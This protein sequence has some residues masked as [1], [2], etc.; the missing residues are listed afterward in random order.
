MIDDFGDR[1]KEYES[2]WT[3]Q[4]I[5]PNGIMCVR[6]DGRSFSKFTKNLK[7]PFDERFSNAMQ[8]TA[9]ELHNEF[10]ADLT[11]VQSD[12]ITMLFKPHPDRFFGGKTSKINSIVA[13]FASVV[14]NK[15]IFEDVTKQEVGNKTPIMDC[16]TWEVPLHEGPNVILWRAKDSRRNYVSQLYRW[17]FGHSKMQKKSVNDMIKELNNNHDFKVESVYCG[18]LFIRGVAQSKAIYDKITYQ[19]IQNLGGETMDWIKDKPDVD[20]PLPSVDWKYLNDNIIAV[21]W[22]SN[23]DCFGYEKIP[24]PNFFHNH[25]TAK[26]GDYHVISGI[27]ADSILKRGTCNWSESLVIRPG[28]KNG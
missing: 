28:F 2:K 8:K 9:Q 13:S 14:F 22:D 17:T 3:S 7:K 4:K 6:V 12:E 15:F 10:N 23:G 19:D 20:S 27:F 18:E 26:I 21:A 25:W 11:Y 5:N 1:M 16:R 24:T